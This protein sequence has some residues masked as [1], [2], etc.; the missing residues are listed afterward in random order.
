MAIHEEIKLFK[1]W[2][3]IVTPLLGKTLGGVQILQT[4]LQN[5]ECFADVSKSSF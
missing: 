1:G 3:Q 5:L 2:G 4:R